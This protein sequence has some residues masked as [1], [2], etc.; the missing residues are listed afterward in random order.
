MLSVVPT[1]VEPY[2]WKTGFPIQACSHFLLEAYH[3]LQAISWN[4]SRKVPAGKSLEKKHSCQDVY[5][6]RTTHWMLILRSVNIVT[7]HPSK[8]SCNMGVHVLE[9]TEHQW[10]GANMHTIITGIITYMN[11]YCCG[12]LRL[13]KSL[14]YIYFEHPVLY[15]CILVHI[16]NLHVLWAFLFSRN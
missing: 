13:S 6:N 3:G 2:F 15:T 7:H 9:Y 1:Y 5:F 8:Q 11:L 4:L 16:T 10:W 14:K 12:S